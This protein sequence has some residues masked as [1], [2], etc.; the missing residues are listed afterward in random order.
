MKFRYLAVFAIIILFFN[1]CVKEDIQ[2][3][4]ILF[5]PI[6]GR[7]DGISKVCTAPNEMSDTICGVEVPNMMEIYIFDHQT[8]VLNDVYGIYNNTKIDYIKSESV[9]AEK[10]H[11]FERTDTA[12]STST[13]FSIQFNEQRNSIFAWKSVTSDV[14][15]KNDLFSGKK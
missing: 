1:A 6:V 13:V 2:T 11:F 7:Y 12:M 4:L 8:I 9:N 15:I 3:D 5:A 10:I 14:S